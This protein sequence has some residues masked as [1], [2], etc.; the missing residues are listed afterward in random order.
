[1]NYSI[2]RA[3][4]R[5]SRACVHIYIDLYTLWQSDGAVSARVVHD[6]RNT[7]LLAIYINVLDSE[8]QLVAVMNVTIRGFLVCAKWYENTNA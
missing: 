1:M 4:F 5:I 8:C 7:S 2:S 3:V 6:S